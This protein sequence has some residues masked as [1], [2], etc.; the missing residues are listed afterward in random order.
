MV[1]SPW[2]ILT[3][4]SLVFFG[5][6]ELSYKAYTE[7]NQNVSANIASVFT[8]IFMILF[9]APFLLLS[10]GSLQNIAIHLNL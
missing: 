4:L 3:L 9:A 1:M 7:Q 6:I 8:N 5:A 10:L 2:L